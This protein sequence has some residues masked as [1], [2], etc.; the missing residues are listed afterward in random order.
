MLKWLAIRA[1]MGQT[2]FRRTVFEFDFTF[3]DQERGRD[4]PLLRLLVFMLTVRVCAALELNIASHYNHRGYLQAVR[5]HFEVLTWLRLKLSFVGK[6]CTMA[7]NRI[8]NDVKA[9]ARYFN[10]KN[11]KC[12]FDKKSGVSNQLLFREIGINVNLLNPSVRI[13]VISNSLLRICL[14]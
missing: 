2:N 1:F 5:Y 9:L 3:T 14:R 10:L 4:S 11:C 8:D 13:S 6:D 12:K 7:P